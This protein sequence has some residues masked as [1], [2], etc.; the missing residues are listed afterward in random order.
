MQ[1][2]DKRREVILFSQVA[3]TQILD[4]Q[5]IR[6]INLYN[7]LKYVNGLINSAQFLVDVSHVVN[8]VDIVR[9]EVQAA[10]VDA[11]GELVQL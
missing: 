6:R 8:S 10:L 1:V 5:H 2:S 9:I 11:E 4:P 7:L 3:V